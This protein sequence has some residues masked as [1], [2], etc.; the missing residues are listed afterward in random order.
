MISREE[1]MVGLDYLRKEVNAKLSEEDINQIFE[2]MDF[3]N[4]GYIDYT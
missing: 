3:D 2:A 4:S 1:M